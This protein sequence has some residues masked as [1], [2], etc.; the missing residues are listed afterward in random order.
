LHRPHSGET[1]E[2]SNSTGPGP[3]RRPSAASKIATAWSSPEV[4]KRSAE[5]PNSASA[6]SLARIGPSPPG[7]GPGP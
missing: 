4:R 2:R 3:R 6:P 5:R 7:G 1:A